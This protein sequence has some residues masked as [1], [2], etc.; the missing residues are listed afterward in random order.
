MKKSDTDY[1]VAWYNYSIIDD[2]GATIEEYL[3]LA[4]DDQN[5]AYKIEKLSNDQYWRVYAYE[6]GEWT[7]TGDIFESDP[8]LSQSYEITQTIQAQSSFESALSDGSAIYTSS[9]SFSGLSNVIG[10]SQFKVYLRSLLSITTINGQ[11]NPFLAWIL[12]ATPDESGI[13]HISQSW[14]QSWGFVGYCDFYDWVFDILTPMNKIK[15]EFEYNEE[16]IVI[17]AW[18]GDY[19]NLGAGAEMGIYYQ[20][21]WMIDHHL[22][23]HFLSGTKFKMPASLTLYENENQLFNWTP[24]SDNPQWWIN[25]FDANEMTPDPTQLVADYWIDFTS[26]TGLYNEFKEEWDPYPGLTFDDITHNV[27]FHFEGSGQ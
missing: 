16:N 8:F 3:T 1:I 20:T 25:G 15:F 19:I 17:W 12:G 27:M 13:Y 4:V 22:T 24:G 11:V 2:N 9:I 6:N 10:E 5:N 14:W 21:E 23:Q 7:A 26:N 18:K